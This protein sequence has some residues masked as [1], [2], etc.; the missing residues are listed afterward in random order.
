MIDL[1]FTQQPDGTFA[2]DPIELTSDT[3]GLHIEWPADA[4]LRFNHVT[5]S[6]SASG[7][8]HVG[9]AIIAAPVSV[10]DR[11]VTGAVAGLSVRISCSV[12]P[13]SAGMI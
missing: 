6:R 12:Q 13:S 11:T 4:D 1:T 5:I 10:L 3:F 7:A 2:T 9:C 8:N